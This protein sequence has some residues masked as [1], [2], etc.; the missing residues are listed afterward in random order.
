MSSVPTPQASSTRDPLRVMRLLWGLQPPP[1]RGPKQTLTIDGIAVAAIALADAE[2]A[3]ALSMRRVADHLGVGPMSL[4]TY[5]ASKAQLIEVI[6]DR[7]CAEIDCTDPSDDWRT[8]L[9]SRARQ[10][11]DLYL[12]HPWV[13]EVASARP[14]LGPY[15]FAVYDAFLRSLID[16]GL[17]GSD[18]AYTVEMLVAYVQ[19]AAAQAIEA[20]NLHTVTGETDDEW[21]LARA[22]F[23][24][25][26][27]TPDRFPTVARLDDER[28]F[29]GD[30]DSECSY[31]LQRAISNF[32]FGLE[33]VLDGIAL[34]IARSRTGV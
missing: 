17:S 6:T 18:V 4:Y 22:P 34:R 15:A 1:S 20:A 16:T 29:D 12:R 14:T 24:D 25:E 33:C 23:L 9:E 2:G 32:E 28:A 7:V 30:P 5:V 3:E 27:V 10:D 31:L 13:L 26:V 19:G 8:N 21:W 11:W